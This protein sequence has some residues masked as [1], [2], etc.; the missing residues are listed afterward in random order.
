MY[1]SEVAVVT[2]MYG[3]MEHFHFAVST[4]FCRWCHCRPC[5][6][7]TLVDGFLNRSLPSRCTFSRLFFGGVE[8][9]WSKKFETQWEGGGSLTFIGGNERS[10]S[11]MTI[12]MICDDADA[13]N[14]NDGDERWVISW[15]MFVWFWF[16]IFRWALKELTMDS[17]K[18]PW[19]LPHLQPAMR[20]LLSASDSPC[21]FDA[22]F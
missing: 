15:W 16:G 7:F 2:R 17:E 6:Y 4:A 12:V 1:L 5:S 19:D 20:C 13:E 11:V 14:D 21:S 18:K 9:R 3:D 22:H 8:R 10:A